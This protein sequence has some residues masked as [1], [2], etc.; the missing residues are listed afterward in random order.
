MGVEYV[1]ANMRIKNFWM[2]AVALGGFLVGE[3]S[4]AA[5]TAVAAE[6]ASVEEGFQLIFD[7]K[8]L[9][10][11]RVSEPKE[12]F[13]VRDGAIVAN[14]HAAHAFYVG[15]E[16]K[17]LFKDF[18]LRLE[19][20]TEPNANGGVY[21]HTSWQA[22]GFPSK[23][24]EVQVN[25]TQGDWRKSG[26]LYAV[27]DNRVPFEDNQ[28]MHYVIRVEDGK[29][30]ISVND[31]ELVDHTPKA[32]DSKLQKDGGLIALQAHDP[33]STVHYRNIRVKPLE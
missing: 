25:N 11:W 4:V 30:T 7:G 16:N 18:E 15:G 6:K 3:S 5:E 2:V 17:G 1:A 20:M 8:S 10:G 28:W 23:G 21:V 26:G 12:S 13:S 33:G 22:G 14:G 19:V 24:Y 31:K 27:V 32:E 9:D 29:I